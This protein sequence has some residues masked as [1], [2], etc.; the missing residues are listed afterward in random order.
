MPL[1][2]PIDPELARE[3]EQL[4]ST[5]RH[6]VL[7][8]AAMR[9]RSMRKAG[10][11]V[12]DDEP[13]ILT[14]DAIA[15]TAME[16]VTWDRE[17]HKTIVAHLCNVVHWR[18]SNEIKKAKK[19]ATTSLEI[20]DDHALPLDGKHAGTRPDV[21]VAQAEHVLLLYSYAR[22]RARSLNDTHMLAIIDAYAR[23]I[24][25]PRDV[26][27]EMGLRRGQFLNAR[28]R[29]DRVL[30]TAPEE[31]RS[32]APTEAIVACCRA[33]TSVALEKAVRAAS[34]SQAASR[35]PRA[36]SRT[37][38]ASRFAAGRRFVHELAAVVRDA[39]SAAEHDIGEVSR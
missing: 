24:D 7:T 35:S 9:T 2:R 20:V 36:R 32:E 15:D 10:I 3:L 31:L 38:C 12:S 19:R 14:N 39:D 17:F 5:D 16:H 4:S 27:A 6:K 21:V 23:R 29:L 28:R 13:E 18:T 1:L 11:P 34:I 26:M 25:K 8:Y 30:A 22:D 33:V 37:R